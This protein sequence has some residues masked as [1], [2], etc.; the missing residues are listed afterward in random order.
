MSNIKTLIGTETESEMYLNNIKDVLDQRFDSSAITVQQVS[1]RCL[2]LSR[3]K[4]ADKI[5]AYLNLEY[6][7]AKGWEIELRV[8]ICLSGIWECCH[9]RYFPVDQ[10]NQSIT[11]TTAK[12]IVKIIRKYFDKMSH[13]TREAQELADSIAVKFQ[14]A[15]YTVAVCMELEGT[16]GW[17]WKLATNNWPSIVLEITFDVAYLVGDTKYSTILTYRTGGMGPIWL[18]YQ[19]STYP[20]E[21]I[22]NIPINKVV[23]A[24]QYLKQLAVLQ[25]QTTDLRQELAQYLRG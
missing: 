7:V 17:Y 12:K 4:I 10:D 6:T 5:H 20:Q 9:R 1:P 22:Y 8:S 11:P 15:G 19:S 21:P 13:F 3:E 14:E 25:Q 24:M 23:E 16:A 2:F 18:T